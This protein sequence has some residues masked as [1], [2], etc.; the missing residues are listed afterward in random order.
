MNSEHENELS[1][2]SYFGFVFLNSIFKWK[3]NVCFIGLL[4]ELYEIAYVAQ[5]LAY[6][7]IS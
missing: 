3:G 5:T 1:Y 4:W 6:G 7:E 2:N